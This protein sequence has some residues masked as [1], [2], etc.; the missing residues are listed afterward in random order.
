MI[1]VQVDSHRFPLV[2]LL[3][4]AWDAGVDTWTGGEWRDHWW[5]WCSTLSQVTNARI[6]GWSVPSPWG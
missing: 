6:N 5:I 4:R 1:V 2:Q 3:E